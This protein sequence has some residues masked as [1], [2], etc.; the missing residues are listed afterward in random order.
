MIP[1]EM[2]KAKNVKLVDDYHQI[3]DNPEEISR[4]RED[5]KAGDVYIFKRLVDPEKIIKIREYLG[6]VGRNS[7]PN[8]HAIKAGAP[9][10]HRLNIWDDR[11]YVK[12]CF[13]SLF[14]FLGI[15]MYLTSFSYSGMGI[16]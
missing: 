5:I 6:G 15:R 7:L 1:F 4:I 8:Y 11:A 13:T 12:G 2:K 16:I 10:F 3:I 9:N 14:S